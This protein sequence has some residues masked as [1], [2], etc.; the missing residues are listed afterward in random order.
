[1]I[2]LIF[3]LPTMILWLAVFVAG[4]WAARKIYR[5]VKHKFFSK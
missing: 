2:A 3:F 5:R 1:M 4:L